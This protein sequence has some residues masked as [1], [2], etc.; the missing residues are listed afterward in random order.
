MGFFSDIGDTYITIYIYHGGKSEIYS[1]PRFCL[2]HYRKWAAIKQSWIL[3]L[4]TIAG[5][6]I[7]RQRSA[8]T[9]QM[10][11]PTCHLCVGFSDNYVNLSDLFVDLS[12]IPLF[13]TSILKRVHALIVP[14][15]W[16]HIFWQV[17]IRILQFG[18]II[19]LVDI[20]F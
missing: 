6:T 14:S 9:C 12:F 11:M 18:I 7:W 16:H 17:D 15:S 1:T 8:I 5:W 3:T 20:T 19:Y 13:K 2:Q 4:N 10:N